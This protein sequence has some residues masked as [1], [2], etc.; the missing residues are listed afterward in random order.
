MYRVHMV[1][2]RSSSPPCSLP[3]AAAPKQPR[4]YLVPAF[5]RSRFYSPSSSPLP[6]FATFVQPPPPPALPNPIST[7]NSNCCAPNKQVTCGYVICP[8]GESR[9][10]RHSGSKSAKSTAAP[11]PTPVGATGLSSATA[12]AAAAAGAGGSR[13]MELRPSS[14]FTMYAHTDLGGVLPASVINKLCKK[15]AYRVLRKVRLWCVFLCVFFVCL[16]V[17]FVCVLCVACVSVV[18]VVSC[19]SVCCT[20][21]FFV[22]VPVPVSARVRVRVRLPVF[23]V[24]LGFALLTVV[25]PGVSTGGRN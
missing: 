5:P 20:Q 4:V 10:R 12:A 7:S 24:L 13:S 14:E 16:F 3:R 2:S 17:C 22:P 9:R 15:P 18:S 19:V 1:E 11:Q 23:V 8:L 21:R 25:L 6:S